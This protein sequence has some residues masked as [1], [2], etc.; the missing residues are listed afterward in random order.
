MKIAL[1]F[2]LLFLSLALEA[3]TV[4]CGKEYTGMKAH[5]LKLFAA[6]EYEKARDALLAIKY[7]PEA[8]QQWIEQELTKISDEGPR[9][10]MESKARYLVSEAKKSLEKD[11]SRLAYLLSKAALQQD[12]TNHEAKQIYDTILPYLATRLYKNVNNLIVSKNHSAIAFLNNKDTSEQGT[13]HLLDL[14]TDKE[15]FSFPQST[16]PQFSPDGLYLIFYSNASQTGGTLNVLPLDS[17]GFLQ[18]FPNAN[19]IYE[20]A[21][22]NP[23]DLSH[24]SPDNKYIT[25]Y[26]NFD[27]N[28]RALNLLELGKN[29]LPQI[30]TKEAIEFYFTKDGKLLL[31]FSESEDGL[32]SFSVFDLEK[33]ILLKSF[34]GKNLRKSFWNPSWDSALNFKDNYIALFTDIKDGQ[35][36]LNI[37]DL[38]KNLEPRIFLDVIVS[39][40]E[41]SQN[42]NYIT[43]RQKKSKFKTISNFLD[44]DE[45]ILFPLPL[46]RSEF[47]RENAFS[48]NK[49]YFSF[50]SNETKNKNIL[51]VY[52]LGENFKHWKFRDSDFNAIRFSPN[53]QYFIFTANKNLFRHLHVFSLA[54][55]EV[56]SAFLHTEM[57][58]DSISVNN[59]FPYLINKP[60]SKRKIINILMLNRK[61]KIQA[62]SIIDDRVGIYQMDF[63][64][65]EKYVIYYTQK[66]GLPTTLNVLPLETGLAFRSFPNAS[67]NEYF[68]NT[69]NQ[70]FAFLTEADDTSYLKTL[71]LNTRE[72]PQIITGCY[73]F[74]KNQ[75]NPKYFTYYTNTN[76]TPFL[77]ILSLETNQPTISFPYA[78]EERFSNDN[79]LLLF[80]NTSRTQ[81]TAWNLVERKEETRFRTIEG[82]QSFG[83]SQYN[84]RIYTMTGMGVLKVLDL[85]IHP[86][87]RRKHYE[88]L[89][90]STDEKRSYGLE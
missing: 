17:T 66:K 9:L 73:F 60:K 47:A 23:L 28:Q 14:N 16:H 4:P 41:L 32:D 57:L 76:K 61:E 36:T 83:L 13:L 40:L 54:S 68:Y 22:E 90:F 69:E 34:R 85:S 1:V 18:S 44:I 52:Q 49:K 25:F 56:F 79:R 45:N 35:G 3:Q 24:F 89:Q 48:N 29:K 82:V 26:T 75:S 64:S 78:S 58:T 33:N 81:L 43:F 50:T 70:F 88:L 38:K 65:D 15:L 37:L 72:E 74:A 27:G 19:F 2:T 30:L 55:N 86:E 11:D 51:N 87:D 5:Y 62:N 20:H 77:N 59:Q 7:C 12:S 6:K 84:D 39:S 67:V 46:I 31:F 10:A 80:Q 63:T 8:D 42:Y 71:R 53:S 21:G